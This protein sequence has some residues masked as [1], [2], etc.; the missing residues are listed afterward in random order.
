MKVSLG[1][2]IIFNTWNILY[3]KNYLKS[4]R[5]IIKNLTIR[6]ISFKYLIFLE[7]SFWPLLKRICIYNLFSKL[8]PIY[9]TILC[10]ALLLKL[11]KIFNPFPQN[12]KRQYILSIFYDTIVSL[13]SCKDTYPSILYSYMDLFKICFYKLV[14]IY[15]LGDFLC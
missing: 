1:Q 14:H 6:I 8:I 15:A 5:K 10:S 13:L 7:N 3:M 4:E 9:F 11:P 12:V 2:I